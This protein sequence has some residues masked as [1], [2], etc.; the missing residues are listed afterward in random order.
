MRHRPFV[1]QSRLVGVPDVI[2][3]VIPGAVVVCLR[4]HRPDMFSLLFS[5]S[6]EHAVHSLRPSWAPTEAGLVRA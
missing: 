1:T 2:L 6:A 4:A 3:V 5:E